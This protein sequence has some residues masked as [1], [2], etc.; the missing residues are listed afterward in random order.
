MYIGYIDKPSELVKS[1]S[2]LA[3]LNTVSLVVIHITV[4]DST[5]VFLHSTERSRFHSIDLYV[6]IKNGYIAA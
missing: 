5:F 4:Q 3:M 1:K 6:N 2:H